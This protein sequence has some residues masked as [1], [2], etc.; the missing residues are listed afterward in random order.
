MRLL[1]A[2]L[3]PLLLVGCAT[4]STTSVVL[5]PEEQNAISLSADGKYRDAALAWQALADTARSPARDR[6]LVFAADAWE[7]AGD[8][9]KALQ[10]LALANRRKLQGDGAFLHDMLSAQFM[11]DAGRGGDAVPLLGQSRDSVPTAL[12]TRWHALRARAFE[13]AGMYF[14]TAA[15]Q[16]WLLQGLSPRE[17]SAGARNIDRQLGR[18]DS[19]QLS[20]RSGGMNPSDPLYPFVARELG[21]RG[22]PLPFPL[23][24]SGLALTQGFPAAERDGYRPPERL[25]VLLPA[26]GSLASAG[27]SVRD[28]I[29]A[30]YYAETRRRPDIRF[31]DSAG[32]AAG[33]QK[34]AK[35]AAADGA[36][37]ILGPLAREEVNGLLDGNE[38]GIGVIALN[39]GQST[40]PGSI[41]FAL[42]PDE[43]GLV[44][45]DRLV[46]R[47]LRRVRVFVQRDDSSQRTLVA[48]REQLRARGGEIVG[49]STV[50]DEVGDLSQALQDGKG[51][52]A[53][54]LA[55]KAPAAR[56]IASQ[57]KTS[58][59]AALPR[60]STS[61]IL[62]GASAR[63]DGDLDGIEFPELPWLLDQ[64]SNLPAPDDLAKRL[65]SA[66]GPAQRLFAFG[67]DAWQLAAYLDRLGSDPSF[68]LRGATGELSL[69]SFGTVQRNPGWAVFSGGRPRPAP[70]RALRTESTS[71]R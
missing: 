49:E 30:A 44:T 34:A 64:R 53:V 52:D 41:N 50:G 71:G 37:L 67:M 25:A 35:Q 1:P 39:R 63:L 7:R 28:G 2:L 12:R 19:Q 5:S 60:L 47:G 15:E 36:Q 17:R 38:P 16:A 4:V 61:L 23:P 66:R 62:S 24:R 14:E 40:A 31:Y 43:E 68:S 21:K 29:L 42:T 6:A 65:S 58:P 54:F 56:L 9:D 59:M 48:F 11:I 8:K 22:L 46:D 13:A 20:Q 70:E 3:I 32:T 26:S 57:L 18:L 51:A 55:V 10:A 27:A 69:D 33:A 45:A